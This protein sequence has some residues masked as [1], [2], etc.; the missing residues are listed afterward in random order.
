MRK[1]IV[2]MD[3][4]RIVQMTGTKMFD[5]VESIELIELLKLDLE[6]G[7]KIAL[8]EVGLKEG[9]TLKDLERVDDLQNMGVMEILGVLREEG[10]KYMLIAKRV[11]PAREEIPVIL[12]TGFRERIGAGR[13]KAMGIRALIFK[14]VAASRMARIIRSVLDGGEGNG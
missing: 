2:E 4:E 14:P 13:T 12:G 3:P 8:M 1:M 10:N 11:V 9:C 7:V 6:K 5:V